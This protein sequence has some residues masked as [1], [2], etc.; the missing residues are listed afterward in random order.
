ML[1]EAPRVAPFDESGTATL[2]ALFSTFV[3][4][5]DSPDGWAGGGRRLLTEHLEGF[6]HASIPHL[7]QAIDAVEITIRATYG[8]VPFSAL[9]LHDRTL[10]VDTARAQ[11]DRPD[12]RAAI[13]A[14]IELAHLAYYGGTSRPAGWAD[15]G[16][17]PLPDDSMAVDPEPLSGI[18]V[19][20]LAAEYEVVI[21]GAGAGGGVAAFELARRGRKVL[22]VERSRPFRNSE[23][24]GNHLQG[25]RLERFDVTAGP[26]AGSP[27]V[28]ERAD[29]STELL[30]GDGSGTDYGLVAMALGGGTRVWQ[31]MSWRF[32]AEDFAMASI[33]GVPEDST[34]V[35]W[36][37]GYDEL[38]PYYQQVEWDLGVSGDSRASAAT[39]APRRT[40]LPMPALRDNGLR[41][42][43]RAAAATLGWETSPI[44]TAINS[45]P[46]DGR[47][48]CVGCAQCVGHACPVDAKN[49][50]HN[51]VIP[52]AIA[53]GYCDLLMSAQVVAIEHDERGSASGVRLVVI[54]EGTVSEHVV[55][56]A[57]VVVSAGAIET[58]RLLL[59]S[60]LGNDWV[61][62][63]HHSHAG[64]AAM[65][66]VAPIRKPH[67]GP[68]HTISTLEFVH[69]RAAPWGGGV[70]FDLPPTLPAGKAAFGRRVHPFGAAHK[71]W[72]RDTAN[73]L[74]TMA[75]LQEIPH[76]RSRVSVD[77]SV[78][79]RFGMPVARLRGEAH[80]ASA[81]AAEFMRQRCV[82]WLVALG[83]E[84]IESNAFAGGS[85]GSEHS[86]GTARMGDDPATSACDARGLLHGT[87]NIY[88]AD[89]SLHPTNGGFN[90]ALTAMACAL[91][92]AA[93]MG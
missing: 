82:D 69:R 84:Q 41:A 79:D 48:A 6:L 42:P 26:G 93:L 38:E 58:P 67:I 24:R 32:V 49:G 85:R 16:F 65:T 62:R 44:P 50:T 1:H 88:V 5:D 23:L 39:R 2:A 25:K 86:A 63:N 43:Y 54:D 35:D 12:W 28:L 29:G 7:R 3:P 81:E 74:G 68:N 92:V 76:A 4:E 57:Q 70:I 61:G 22:L 91:R 71:Q 31:G 45:I 27:R 47:P 72:M 87:R 83:G 64:A 19:S 77:R 36:P 34:L 73:P 30:R 21:V 89:A 46:R 78:R 40:P 9:P 37:F 17:H 13:D 90:P 33:Y 53:T 75:M 51:T 52:R 80:P 15:T 60:G 55:R 56:A 11:A 66:T 59:A 20:R 8:D 10:V 14:S 18:P